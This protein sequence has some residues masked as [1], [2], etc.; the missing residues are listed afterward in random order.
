MAQ[1][2]RISSPSHPDTLQMKPSWNVLDPWGC[3]W[4]SMGKIEKKPHRPTTPQEVWI[5]RASSAIGYSDVGMNVVCQLPKEPEELMVFNFQGMIQEFKN[6][7]THP[8]LQLN[9]CL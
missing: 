5:V 7:M 9:P 6:H 2:M 4:L 3:G 8:I 1:N